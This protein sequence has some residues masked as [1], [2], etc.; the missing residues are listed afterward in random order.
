MINRL[1]LMAFL[2]LLLIPISFA[3]ESQS[4]TQEFIRFRAEMLKNQETLREELKED[5]HRYNDENYRMLDQRTNAFFQDVRKQVI[6]GVLGLNFFVASIMGFVY[7]WLN[8]KHSVMA[9]EK[10]LAQKTKQ[11]APA[12]V[13][14]APQEQQN[15]YGQ[16]PYSQYAQYPQD[17]YSQFEKYPPPE[18]YQQY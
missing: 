1:V 13:Q 11:Q 14:T 17:Q 10:K 18:Q 6:I 15:I 8:K 4:L 3:Q 12:P 5:Y 9:F 7:N 2:M 16:D